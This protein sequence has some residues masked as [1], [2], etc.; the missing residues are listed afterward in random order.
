MIVEK[1][2]DNSDQIKTAGLVTQN[3]TTIKFITHE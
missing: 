1:I 3:I 2:K